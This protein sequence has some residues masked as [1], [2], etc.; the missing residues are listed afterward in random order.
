[1]F[2]NLQSATDDEL[3]NFALMIIAR[4]AGEHIAAE[5]SAFDLTE[6]D[7]I[8]DE[9]ERRAQADANDM[10]THSTSTPRTNVW[11]RFR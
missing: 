11:E 7:Q 8:N 3:Y 5:F 1:M 6:L 4:R 10:L 2:G 9:W